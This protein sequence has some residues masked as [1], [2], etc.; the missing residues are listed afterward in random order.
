MTGCVALTIPGL[1]SLLWGAPLPVT[2]LLKLHTWSKRGCAKLLEHNIQHLLQTLDKFIT[3][4]GQSSGPFFFGERYS[5]VEVG[6]LW[7]M[8][9]GACQTGCHG[10]PGQPVSAA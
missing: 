7:D 1:H 8:R 6:T 5:Y 9:Q 10:C 3:Q 4:F 2:L